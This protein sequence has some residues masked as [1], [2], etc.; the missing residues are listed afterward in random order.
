[1]TIGVGFELS[2]MST[3]FP[4]PHDVPMDYIVT[5]AGVVHTRAGAH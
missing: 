4:Q 2:R 5:E 3:I 1:V